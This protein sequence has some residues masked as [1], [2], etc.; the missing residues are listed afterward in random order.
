MASAI[1]EDGFKT[2]ITLTSPSTILLEEISVTAPGLSNGGGIDQT[3]MRNTAWRT[4]APKQLLTLTPVSVTVKYNPEVEDQLLAA[5]GIG[6]NQSIILTWP[7]L[8]TLT[9]WGFID[10]F[11]PGDLVE[12]SLPTATMTIIPT[13]RNGSNAETAPVFTAAA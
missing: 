8:S 10:E 1:L 6:A 2:I 4:M 3:T 9:F 5:D 13:N 7:D 11:T 12:G